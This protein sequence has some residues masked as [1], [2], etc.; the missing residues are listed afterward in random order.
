MKAKAFLPHGGR[1]AVVEQAFSV[2]ETPLQNGARIFRTG[3][4][5][6]VNALVYFQQVEEA[7]GIRHFSKES[8]GA[9]T[10][11]KYLWEN[12][13]SAVPKDN[14]PFDHQVKPGDARKLVKDNVPFDYLIT[15]PFF[16]SGKLNLAEEME[17]T[18]KFYDLVLASSPKA[19]L[20]IYAQWMPWN[21]PTDMS[22]GQSRTT[23]LKEWRD[24][25]EKYIKSCEQL[26]EQLQTKYPEHKLRIIPCASALLALQ[27]AIED[28]QIPGIN[29]YALEMTSD[30]LHLSLKGCYFVSLVH[31]ACLY[32]K[33]PVGLVVADTDLTIEQQT[34]MQEIAWATAK[35]YKWA[36]LEK[37]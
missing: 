11:T 22:K 23:T 33:S 34:K 26:R 5:F 6:T 14:S 12:R 30:N 16:L 18:R 27:Q 35:T 36:S 24:R 9:G 25:M 13:V 2:K 1:S 21:L 3:N 37:K 31:Y 7:A 4:S 10:T 20:W 32:G 29:N 15:Q 17:Y 28:G 19:D 8:L